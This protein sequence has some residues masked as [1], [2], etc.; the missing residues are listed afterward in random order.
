MIE[1]VEKEDAVPGVPG[2]EGFSAA[3]SPPG[4]VVV[5]LCGPMSRARFHVLGAVTFGMIACE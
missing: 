1:G 4:V 3:G 2:S 5:G